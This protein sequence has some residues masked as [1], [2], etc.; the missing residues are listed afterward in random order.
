LRRIYTVKRMGLGGLGESVRNAR[1]IAPLLKNYL[2]KA[3]KLVGTGKIE[4]QIM[5]VLGISDRSKA[6]R[7]V[8]LFKI[9]AM[10]PQFRDIIEN[11]PIQPTVKEKRASEVTID[12]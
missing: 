1:M 9:A 12:A 8:D 11:G 6:A 5:Q 7:L 3:I 4:E 2:P 10:M